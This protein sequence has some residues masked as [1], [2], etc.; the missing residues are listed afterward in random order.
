VTPKL[1]LNMGLRYEYQ[2]PR[3]DR[4]NQLT[5]FDFNGAVPLMAPGLNLHGVLEYP[6]TD[7]LSRGLTNPDRNNFGPRLG[8]SYHLTRKT[9]L[10]GGS[11]IFYSNGLLA[12][13][14]GLSGFSAANSV[15]TSIDGFRPTNYI[16]NP[17]PNG[18]VRP[19]GSKLG[20]ATMLGQA[21]S[22]IQRD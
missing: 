15:V 10:R 20:A 12:D 17:F 9:V 21:V 18:L 14:G 1:T 13:T 8:Y 4:Y 19:T 7:G 5:N 3:T 6:G 22:F 2:A 16:D 11:G